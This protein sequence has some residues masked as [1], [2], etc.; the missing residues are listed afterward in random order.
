[1]TLGVYYRMKGP[2]TA[3]KEHLYES[4]TKPPPTQDMIRTILAI[5]VVWA[6][7]AGTE[8]VMH[9]SQ[10]TSILQHCVPRYYIEL[11]LQGYTENDSEQ[12]MPIHQR[13]LI[14]KAGS[15]GVHIAST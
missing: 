11:E 2:P 12:T 10:C 7:L 6:P 1:M 8:V 3:S 13:V 14:P 9:T 5:S 4:R 15:S